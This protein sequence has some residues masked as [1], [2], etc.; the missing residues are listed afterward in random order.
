MK[1]NKK[2]IFSL[3]FSLQHMGITACCSMKRQN[4]TLHVRIPHM[5][6]G[7]APIQYFIFCSASG[8]PFRSRAV[9]FATE[10]EPSLLSSVKSIFSSDHMQS[11]LLC[12]QSFWSLSS[13]PIGLRL[14][15]RALFILNETT[16]VCN[17]CKENLFPIE[18]VYPH[19][20]GK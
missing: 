9:F 17:N 14:K 6:S 18:L 15:A 5:R 11:D 8:L 20:Y 12:L 13:F 19:W 10:I 16:R 4:K 3:S 1:T 2:G 7:I